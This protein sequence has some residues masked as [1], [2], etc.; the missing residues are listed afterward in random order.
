MMELKCDFPPQGTDFHPKYTGENLTCTVQGL[1]RSTQYKF[2]V[3][4]GAS[5]HEGAPV[6]AVP[7]LLSISGRFQRNRASLQSEPGRNHHQQSAFSAFQM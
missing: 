3:S 5:V 7:P 1:K 2:R 6:T 4:G